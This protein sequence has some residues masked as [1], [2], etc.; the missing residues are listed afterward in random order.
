MNRVTHKLILDIKS[1]ISQQT[2]DV[3]LNDSA[4]RLEI[5]FAEDNLAYKISSGCRAVFTAEKPDGTIL[6]NDCA[7]IGNSVVFD[8]TQ[9]PQIANILGEVDCQVKL[10]G[11][12]NDLITSPR[13]TLVV[14]KTVYRE[15]DA[16]E[17]SSEFTALTKLIT[18]ANKALEDIGDIENILNPNIF[19]DSF[20]LWN[21]WGNIS[22][23]IIGQA[24][25]PN[26][27]EPNAVYRIRIVPGKSYNFTSTP[28]GS[29]FGVFF[30]VADKDGICLDFTAESIDKYDVR[31]DY[32]GTVPA[33]IYY[34]VADNNNISSI[35]FRGETP[36]EA[37]VKSVNGKT[38]DVKLSAEDVGARASTWMPSYSDVGAEKSGTATAEVGTHNTSE[39][40]HND[41][42]LLIE[43]LTTRLNALANSDD[44]TLDQMAEVVTYIKDNRELIEQITTGKVSV[45]D[46]I[47]N[48]T[49]NVS[50]KPLSAKQG[51]ALKALIDAIIV[52]TKLSE[53]LEDAS[54]RLV[55]D[56][57]KSA[58]NAKSNFSGAYADLTGKPTIPTQTSQLTNDSKYFK[59]ESLSLGI[60]SDG[61]IYLFVDGVPV[62]TGIPQ[63]QS[64][65]VFGYVDENNTIVLN[66]NLADGTYSVKYEM[67]DGSTIDI[68]D[69]SL[70]EE[71]VE[72]V[73]Q[74]PL[75]TD[76]DGSIYNDVGYMTNMRINS[77][78]NAV[79]YDGVSVTGFIPVKNGDTVYLK[80]V[81]VEASGM[82]KCHI[83]DANKASL[84]S[85]G[86]SSGYTD[87]GDGT[88]QFTLNNANAAFIR[89]SSKHIMDG[90]EIITINQPIS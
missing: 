43:G 37:P 75:S 63:G 24:L 27:I 88:Y 35:E 87:N 2:L 17:S 56:T 54:H 30:A 20:E 84:S 78:G 22:A 6:Y 38:G 64:G 68:G 25:S 4:R 47:D 62:G 49:T 51:V 41:I 72:I 73:N 18:E 48:L 19:P 74:I 57:E 11:M 16:V 7:I 71:P 8:F 33:Y 85:V 86:S 69:L 10:Y 79:S 50:N 61:L 70:G 77:S 67:E 3:Y 65:D 58:W 59:A 60:A 26:V 81:M 21:E 1:T 66:G 29:E 5:A 15:G 44:T 82:S 83:Y 80:G 39:T 40:S 23:P 89:C 9:N 36:T 46:I 14:H 42:R 76:T 45:T 53:L 13:F 55:T 32:A 28:L 90:S 12:E 52:P 31:S 34:G